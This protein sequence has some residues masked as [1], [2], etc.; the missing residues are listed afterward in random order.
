MK[1][2]RI[3][4][5]VPTEIKDKIFRY[6]GSK[7]LMESIFPVCEEWACVV[8]KIIDERVVKM[9][10]TVSNDNLAEI[11]SLLHPSLQNQDK[12]VLCEYETALLNSKFQ[13]ESYNL[14]R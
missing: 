11:R 9:L 1:I 2:P 7:Y 12:Y 3:M 4:E 14:W 10:S 5:M 8:L 13:I 6:L